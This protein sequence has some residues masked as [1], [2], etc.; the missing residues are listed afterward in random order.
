MFK[1]IKDPI[2]P[3]YLKFSK[4]E[5]SLIDTTEFKRL[6]NIKQLGSLDQVFPG[7]CHTRFAHSLG[8]G[9]LAEKFTTTL[10]NNSAIPIN[11]AKTRII[12]NIKIAGLFHDIGHGPFS[13]VFD[14]MVLYKLCP[15]NIY[16]DHEKR[17]LSIFEDVCKK[18]DTKLFTGYDIDFIKNCID[19]TE[20]IDNY[21][22]QVVANKINS[23]DVDK[24][25]YLMRDPYHLGFS[26]NFDY[27]RLCNKIKIM[28]GE[29]YYSE[30]V[31]NDIFDMY[32]TR[33]K[34]HRDIYNHKAV[35][36]IELMIGDIMLESNDIYNYPSVLDTDDFIGLD[37]T[38]LTRIKYNKEPCLTGCKQLIKRIEKRDIYK[39]VYTGNTESLETVKDR[40]LDGNTDLGEENYHFIEMHFDFCNGSESPFHNINFYRN[41]DTKIL[42]KNLNIIKLVPNN[43]KE[44]VVSVYKK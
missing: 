12:R 14:H 39:L 9:H 7:A 15:N 6:K 18:L 27:K 38:I 36:S 35:K 24:F 41:E 30:T 25:D 4:D 29:I 20:Y 31:A 34:F 5:L 28:D 44:T 26:Y 16:K 10:Y 42:H 17:S 2:Y 8:V 21:I 19:P 37:D 40:I 32:Y 13:H 11:S 1:Y 43:F 23:I 33:Y 3:D 22:Y